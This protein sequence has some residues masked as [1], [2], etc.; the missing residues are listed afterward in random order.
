MI[1][2]VSDRMHRKILINAWAFI[3]IITYHGDGGG[4]LLEA[5][6]FGRTYV[7]KVQFLVNVATVVLLGKRKC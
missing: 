7:R 4:H 2:A 3:R 1:Q 5:I 6:I